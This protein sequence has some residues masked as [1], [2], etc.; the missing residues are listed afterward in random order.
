[1]SYMKGLH[2]ELPVRDMKSPM[3]KRP[4]DLWWTVYTLDRQLSSSLGVPVSVQDYDISTPLADA[5]DCAAED[6]A[7]VLK[8]KLSQVLSTIFN[9]ES[10]SW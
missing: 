3:P 2:T 6:C 1:M 9:S 7:L 10:T 8:V 4:R 5:R